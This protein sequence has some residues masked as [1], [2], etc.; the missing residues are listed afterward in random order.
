MPV[1]EA[2]LSEM[3]AK[4]VNLSSH[5]QHAKDKKKNRTEKVG[6]ALVIL[7]LLFE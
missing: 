2:M 4:Y 5:I 1:P 6:A 3:P 7:L